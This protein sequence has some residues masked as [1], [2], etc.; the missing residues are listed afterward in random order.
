MYL[1]F[2]LDFYPFIVKIY[3]NLLRIKDERNEIETT[4]IELCP[5][6]PVKTIG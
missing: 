2:Y 4:Y 5:P 1:K 6:T 3:T